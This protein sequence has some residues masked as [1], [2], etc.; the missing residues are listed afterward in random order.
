M[1]MFMLAT[2][3]SHP[4]IPHRSRRSAAQPDEW[5]LDAIAIYAHVMAGFAMQVS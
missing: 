3:A 5:R 4:R 1:N 2:S